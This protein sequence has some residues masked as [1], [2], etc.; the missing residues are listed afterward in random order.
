MTV[1]ER[2]DSRWSRA[3]AAAR[4]TVQSSDGAALHAN[5]NFVNAV[6]SV[7]IAG[8]FLSVILDSSLRRLFVG[9]CSCCKKRL[10]LCLFPTPVTC[11]AAP[12]PHAR[13]PQERHR[14]MNATM[15]GGGAGKGRP[16]NVGG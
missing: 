10:H 4:S 11:R 15:F 12:R 9:V 3:T 16:H 14:H 1:L 13:C 5:P 6:L 2:L 8:I 7:L